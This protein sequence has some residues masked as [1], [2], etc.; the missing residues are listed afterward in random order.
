MRVFGS[1]RS[2]FGRSFFRR[3]GT[4]VEMDEELRS[5]IAHRA[6][7]LERAGLPRAEAV[8]R[9]RVE[10]GGYERYRQESYE[11][12]GNRFFER[13]VQDVR[14]GLRVLLKSPGFTLVA[15]LTLALAIGANAVVFSM[16][17]GLVLRP[18][19]VPGAKS[20]ALIEQGGGIPMQSYPD[21]QDLRE[22][23][24]SFDDLIAYQ[25]TRAGLDTGRSAVPAWVYEASGN[26][27]DALGIQPYLGRFFHASDEHGPN[28]SPYIVLSHAYWSSHFDGDRGAVGRTIQLN[29]H[30]YV[31]LG[32]APP[33]FRGTELFFSPDFWVPLVDQEQVDGWSLLKNRSGRAVEV[34]GHL[35]AGVTPAQATADLNSIAAYL[36]K[37]YPKDD[38]RWSF[39]L[40]QPGLAGDM[41]GGPVRAFLAALTALAALILLAACA[42]LGSLF[43]AR[44]ADR[45]KE[46]ALRLALGSSRRRILRQLLTEA[47]MVSLMGGAAG[48]LGSVLLLHWLSVWRPVSSFPI[49]V[50][51]SPDAH[52]YAVALLLAVASGLLFGA[53][54]VRQVLRA[55]P[56]EVVKAG[57]AA[58]VGRRLTARDL[59]LM[60][61]IAI[62]AVLVT[63]SLVAVR[64]LVRS[65]HSSFGFVP[66]GAMLVD[67]DLDMAGYSGDQVPI[68]QRRAIDAVAAIPGVTMTGMVDRHPLSLGWSSDVVF[69]D[70]TTDRRISNAAAEAT[71]YN[72]SPDY[73]QAAHTALLT[74]RSFTWHDDKNAPRVA[75][76]N[77][78]FAR[79]V[80]G[81]SAAAVGGYYRKIDGTRIQVVGIV[82]DGKYETLTE[83][84]QPAM[85][86]PILQSPTSSTCLVVR[87][88]RDSAQLAAALQHELRHLDAGLP[89]TI[90]TWTSDMDSALFPSRAATISLGVLG[91]LGGMLAVTGIFGMAAYSVSKRLREL[92]IRIALGA[93]RRE[94]LR[95]ALGRAVRLLT[96]GS[97]AGLVLGLAATKVLSFIV[98]Q[99]SPRDPLVLCGVVL[100]MAL[101]GLVAAWIPAQR[102]LAADPLMLLREE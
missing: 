18:L 57:S 17:N 93:Q 31:I 47:V 13:L 89:F 20:L 78:E 85:F 73:F 77:K 69:K 26:Y 29:K 46:I 101:L 30:P 4:N 34:L 35:K 6:D 61:Q 32:V 2:L 80:F 90:K 66:Q 55:N 102:A 52:V 45:A 71:V 11:A 37:T 39:K 96:F 74:G 23:N 65:Q 95:T 60:V 38:D 25:I 15:V 75:V 16:L 97:V 86:F 67:T 81:S 58:M 48:L 9:A 12:A 88:N 53:V 36:A 84:Q 82:E 3:S 44:A 41:L 49:R 8:R 56:Y 83:E 10:F 51:V 92:G 87:S 70:G 94:V 63:S 72:I 33:E 5:H 64:G 28:S 7:D 40:A 79:K 91:L 99:A 42:N 54:P 98:Y 43:A 50:P 59:L 100:I 22:R 68:M 24:R 62:C 14:F 21:Y 19:N 76:V 27:F 1:F